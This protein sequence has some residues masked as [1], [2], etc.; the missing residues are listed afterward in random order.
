[1]QLPNVKASIRRFTRGWTLQEFIAPRTVYFYDCDWQYR[2][3]KESLSTMLCR[4]SGIEEDILLHQRSLHSICVAQKMS[5][6]SSRQTTRIEDAAYSLLGLFGVNMPLLYGEEERAFLRLQEEIIKSSS[7][8]S[9]LAW[10]DSTNQAIREHSSEIHC[11]V[12]AK[13]PAQF[14]MAGSICGSLGADFVGESSVTNQGIRLNI[15]LCIVND[16]ILKKKSYMMPLH[17]KSASGTELGIRLE[18]IG[19]EMFLRND[20]CSLVEYDPAS[21]TLAP[22][23]MYLAIRV[24][25]ALSVDNEPNQYVTAKSLAS[26]RTLVL[27]LD[28]RTDVNIYDYWGIYNHC[29]QTFF[30]SSGRSREWVALRFSAHVFSR[31][32]VGT[33]GI[34]TRVSDANVDCMLF[35]T[36]W[37]S[38]SEHDM[39]YYLVNVVEHANAVAEV[40]KFFKSWQHDGFPAQAILDHYLPDTSSI[41]MNVPGSDLT[42]N[43]TVKSAIVADTAIC[44]RPFWKLQITR[45]VKLD[46]DF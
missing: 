34:E 5:W 40:Q 43:I 32:V 1:M 23:F 27:A 7:D 41:E 4:I 33:G 38:N 25:H 36:G 30:E 13:S 45:S 16:S 22:R 44:S 28:F 11:G 15:S 21:S 9:I 14:S 17:C 8:L 26:L 19:D 39:R 20:P 42:Y 10:T 35:V 2:G 24:P 29:N 37:T 46:L 31:D 3:S 12:L 18:K 6:A